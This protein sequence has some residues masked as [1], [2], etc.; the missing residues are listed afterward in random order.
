ME[1]NNSL[2]LR[3]YNLIYL[4]NAATTPIAP[5][6]IEVMTEILRIVHGNPS[7]IHQFG[8]QAKA[9]KA[10]EKVESFNSIL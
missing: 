5:E 7:S 3:N 4:D 1:F 6:V 8:R 9:L 2:S 10:L